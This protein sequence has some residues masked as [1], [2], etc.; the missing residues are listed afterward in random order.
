MKRAEEFNVDPTKI[1]I[2]G[3]SAGSFSLWKCIYSISLFYKIKLF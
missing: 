2:I 1:V 3:D